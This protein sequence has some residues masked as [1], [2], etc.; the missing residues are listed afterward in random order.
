MFLHFL[1]N[2]EILNHKIIDFNQIRISSEI[3]IL[4]NL[5]QQKIDLDKFKLNSKHYKTLFFNYYIKNILSTINDSD[6]KLFFIMTK[7]E[8]SE[9][10]NYFDHD[11]YIK[12]YHT[13]LSK[14]ISVLPILFYYNK[15]YTYTQ[16]LKYYELEWNEMI[17][18]NILIINESIYKKQ[19]NK[20]HSLIS[21]YDLVYL[22]KT[23]FDD[24]KNT[25]K[26]FK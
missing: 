11:S 3:N 20:I 15:D 10:F 12:S 7:P 14:L 23:I 1:K 25:F 24:I 18:N 19:F 2:M 17:I 16:L 5:W 13:N 6:K 22:N 21:Y 8:E 4:D 9:I 26:F